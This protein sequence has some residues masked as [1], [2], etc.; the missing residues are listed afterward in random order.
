[1]LAIDESEATQYHTLPYIFSSRR[2]GGSDAPRASL[3]LL[4]PLQTPPSEF[5]RR[6]P[7]L[8]GYNDETSRGLA[9]A[10]ATLV[11]VLPMIKPQSSRD[12]EQWSGAGAGA[13]AGTL[14][15][16]SPDLNRHKASFGWL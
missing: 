5:P 12:H 15:L 8:D 3:L 10:T 7:P 2:L 9:A 14:F 4:L 6:R 16:C 13:G 11:Q 1:M